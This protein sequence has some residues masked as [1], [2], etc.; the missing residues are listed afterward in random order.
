MRC[1][2]MLDGVQAAGVGSGLADLPLRPRQCQPPIIPRPQLAERDG[3][4][5]A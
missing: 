2:L 3:A 4:G 5:A 1:A